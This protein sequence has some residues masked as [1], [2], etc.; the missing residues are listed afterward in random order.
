[1]P[2]ASLEEIHSKIGQSLGASSWIEITQE[3][4]DAFANATEDRQFIHI[5]PELA[6]KTPFGGT[7]AH[8]FLTLS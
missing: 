4:V 1:M 3:R 7:I 5:D 6:G 8:G 2:I